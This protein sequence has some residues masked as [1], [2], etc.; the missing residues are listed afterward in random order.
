MLGIIHA[1]DFAAVALAATAHVTRA[2]AGN[3]N[4]LLRLLTGRR[5][6][7]MTFGRTCCVRQTLQLQRGDNILAGTVAIFTKLVERQR[8]KACCQYNRTVFFRNQLIGLRV[9]NCSCR[10]NLGA[11]ATFTGLELDAGLAVNNR[12][13]RNGLCKGNIDCAAILQSHI[14]FARSF[15]GRTFFGT[16]AAAA[17]H[18]SL[19]AA[20]FFADCHIK[21]THKAAYAFY[22]AIGIERN[23]FMIR[24]I[25]HLRC[26]DAGRAVEC[27]E[28]FVELRHTAADCR[29]LL[30]NIYLVAC[31]CNIQRR[32]NTGNTAADN[33]CALHYLA[34]AR[35]QRSI[36]AHLGNCCL[37]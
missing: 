12:H 23:I 31:F 6:N 33:Q 5:T 37:S 24:C 19:H 28:G 3:D 10:A 36:K 25:H 8:L 18:I 7:E 22:L 4:N 11:D 32:L 14:E 2:Y 13:L 1:A 26:Q 20:C 17:A 21:I 35:L 16:N 27:R 34:F 15:A 30:H 29:L 9:I